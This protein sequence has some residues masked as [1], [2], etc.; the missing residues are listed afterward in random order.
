VFEFSVAFPFANSIFG[1]K[2][3]LILPTYLLVV[4]KKLKAAAIKLNNCHKVKN[5]RESLKIA[6][7]R[8][9]KTKQRALQRARKKEEEENKIIKMK[10]DMKR[11]RRIRY[12]SLQKRKHGN[13]NANTVERMKQYRRKKKQRLHLNNKSELS[14]FST[15]EV[16][17]LLEKLNSTVLLPENFE[18]KLQHLK[19]AAHNHYLKTT[20]VDEAGEVHRAPVCVVCDELIIKLDDMQWIEKKTLL[21]HSKRLG[22]KEYEEHHGLTLPESLKRQ[23]MVIDPEL[24]DLLLSPRARIQNT[25]YMCCSSCKSSLRPHMKDKVPPRLAIA[26]GFVIGKVPDEIITEEDITDIL[27]AMIAPVRPF[28]HIVSYEAGQHRTIRG[29]VTF[30]QNN[31]VHTGS[32]LQNYFRTGA[33]PNVYCVMCGRFTPE[34]REIVKRKM[35]L[36]ITVFKKLVKWYIEESGHPAFDGLNPDMKKWPQPVVLEGA[37]GRNNTDEEED[38]EVE[39][40]VEGSTYYFPS[41]YE[42]NSDTGTFSSQHEFARSMINETAP[43]LLFMPGNYANDRHT[44]LEDMFPLV[45]P[46][47]QGALNMKFG[48]RNR[49]SVESIMEHYMKLSLPQFHRPDF[50][51]TLSS[52]KMRRM[53]FKTGII[54]CKSGQRGASLAEQFSVLTAD[55]VSAATARADTGLGMSGTAGRFLSAVSTSCRPQGHSKEAAMVARRKLMAFCDL[56]GIPNLFV[57]VTPDD[58]VSFRIKIFARGG[59]AV[60]LPSLNWSDQECIVDLQVRETIRAK[61]PGMCSLEFQSVMDFMWKYIVGWDR[62]KMEGTLGVFGEPLAACEADEEQGRKTLHSHWLIWIKDFSFVRQMCYHSDNAIREAARM[63]FTEYVQKTMCASYGDRYEVSHF[64]QVGT[65]TKSIED[66]FEALPDQVVRDGRHKDHCFSV[67]G[68]FPLHVTRITCLQ[69]YLQ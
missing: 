24:K 39:S 58:S 42:P 55:Q 33:N 47:A 38:P 8:E 63:K 19:S 16:T 65:V 37:Q 4:C 56:F 46:Y 52:M 49:V 36:N 23:Y 25:E 41:A 54:K 22:S 32:V 31:V 21:L 48:R 30:F 59:D 7:K 27:V 9:K 18:E 68:K 64:C 57:T 12:I 29:N 44:P 15:D 43:T 51:H 2:A 66:A 14:P 6:K 17:N 67:E 35:M 69:I 50:V 5:M 1:G 62:D 40:T 26:N 60:S 20:A 45:F 11:K 13:N 34:Q 28:M 53:A 61:Y 10:K 3:S